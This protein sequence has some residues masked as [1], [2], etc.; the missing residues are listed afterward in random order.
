MPTVLV[1]APA[2]ATAPTTA[3]LVADLWHD[4]TCPEGGQC[5]A[6][7]VHALSSPMVNS[8]VLGTFIEQYRAAAG[9]QDAVESVISAGVREFH[10]A[11]RLVVRTTLG[12]AVPERAVRL[13][14]MREEMRELHAA[15]AA[16]DVVET[17]DAL[18]DIVYLA[19]GDAHVYG[20]PLDVVLAEVHRSNMTKVPL[21]GVFRYRADGKVLKPST[22]REPELA[23][24]LGVDVS[25]EWIPMDDA[26]PAIFA[27]RLDVW[28]APTFTA[29]EGLDA[30]GERA[31][32]VDAAG[33]P[34]T[35]GGDLWWC[36]CGGTAT[37]WGSAELLEEVGGTGAVTL[38]WGRSD[39]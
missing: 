7:S 8:G 18:G 34:W 14:M 19:F 31:V 30:L 13:R 32:V 2:A 25:K 10:E 27:G 6:R 16:G 12:V 9:P 38:M 11:L 24:V 17:A 28:D 33:H 20:I 36:V 39:A 37:S 23:A 35:K 3:R 26:P 21:D 15:V 29:A 22:F 1:P 4:L 5:P